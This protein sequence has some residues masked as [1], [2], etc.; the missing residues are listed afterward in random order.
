MKNSENNNNEKI[1]LGDYNTLKVVKQV[2]FGMYLDGGD[3]GDILL[4]TRYVPQGLNIGDEIEVFL[5]LD[6]DEK[7]I[8]TT[9]KPLA[10]VGDFA[11]LEVLI[12]A[13]LIASFI[14]TL[15]I[16]KC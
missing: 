4:P 5:Y 11:Y 1:R 13:C 7:I 8:A 15:S 3:T 14:S 2:D 10:K 12:F 9:L 16:V 6:Q